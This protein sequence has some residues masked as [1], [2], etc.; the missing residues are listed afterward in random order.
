MRKLFNYD[1]KKYKDIDRL[2][3]KDME[4]SAQQI[5]R[6]ENY[7]TYVGRKEDEREYELEKRMRLKKRN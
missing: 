4:A 1:P 2:D 7:S 5:L 6:E 3:D